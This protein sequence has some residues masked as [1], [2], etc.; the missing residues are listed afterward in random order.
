MNIQEKVGDIL[1]TLSGVENIELKNHLKEDLGIDSL[2]MV[3]LLLEIEEKFE[4]M[5]DESDMNTNCLETVQQVMELIRKYIGGT[6]DCK[7]Y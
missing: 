4:I 2:G 7:T 1:K 6:D 5:L 3:L